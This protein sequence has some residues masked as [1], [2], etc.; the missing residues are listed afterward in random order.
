MHALV[1]LQRPPTGAGVTALGALQGEWGEVRASMLAQGTLAGAGEVAVRTVEGVVGG[2]FDPYMRLEVALHG[3]T[4]VAQVARKRLLTRV[5][6]DMALQ[7]RV[8]LELGVALATLERAVSCVRA[9]VNGE[10][11]GVAAGVGADLATEGALVTMD[12]QVLLEAAGVSGCVVAVVAL[13]GALS[14]MAAAV[15]VELISTTEALVTQLT[16]IRFLTSVCFQVS[17]HIFLTILGFECT[18]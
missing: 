11:T 18:A 9:Q 13:V 4:V 7:I 1:R 6:A 17:L 15:H 14:R 2:M 3:R 12:P 5:D 8:D 10:L 16:F